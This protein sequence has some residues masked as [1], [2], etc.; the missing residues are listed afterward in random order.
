MPPALSKRISL[1]TALLSAFGQDKAS[2]AE[3]TPAKPVDPI[4]ERLKFLAEHGTSSLREGE[5]FMFS[6]ESGEATLFMSNGEVIR[7][8][9]AVARGHEEVAQLRRLTYLFRKN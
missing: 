3:K 1:V 6:E 8:T 7:R 9:I 2:V 4:D 5:A